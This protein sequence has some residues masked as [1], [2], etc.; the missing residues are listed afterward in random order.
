MPTAPMGLSPQQALELSPQESLDGGWLD[1]S[2]GE[3]A[4]EAEIWH[5]GI[6]QALKFLL[7]AARTVSTVGAGDG[8]HEH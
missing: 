6:H 1:H 4:L 3:G 5:L 8:E 2:R 7:V